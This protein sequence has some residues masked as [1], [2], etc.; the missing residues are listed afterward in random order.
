[1]LFKERRHYWKTRF[2]WE[3]IYTLFKIITKRRGISFLNQE[4]K[5]Q[6]GGDNVSIHRKSGKG[7]KLKK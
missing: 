7:K 6:W 4:G 2:Y 5:K 1:M 3:N